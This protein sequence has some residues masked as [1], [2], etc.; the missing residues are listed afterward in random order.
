MNSD[1]NL[2]RLLWVSVVIG[3]I[4]ASAIVATSQDLPARQ[5]EDPIM[6]DEVS[7]L[8]LALAATQTQLVNTQ[9][10][11]AVLLIKLEGDKA[12]AEAYAK[13]GVS[14]SQYTLDP[15]RFVFVPISANIK[16]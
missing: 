2:K 3:C 8:K 6:V 11:L 9:R 14:P 4:I 5:K 15:Q 1:Q 10:E 7:Q 12:T 13:A 16:P